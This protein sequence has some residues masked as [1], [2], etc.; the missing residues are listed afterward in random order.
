MLLLPVIICARLLARVPVQSIL[1]KAGSLS[2][3]VKCSL[4]GLSY[5]V[6]SALVRYYLDCPVTG[7]THKAPDTPRDELNWNKTFEIQGRIPGT[8]CTTGWRRYSKECPGLR[9]T[10]RAY[11]RIAWIATQMKICEIKN[12]VLSTITRSSYQVMVR[13]TKEIETKPSGHP[14]EIRMK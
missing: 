3:L 11:R 7:S 9:I 4:G 6:N 13:K 2:V 12:N 10:R 5:L 1:V 8:N 14:N